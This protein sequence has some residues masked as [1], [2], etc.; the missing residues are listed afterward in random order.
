MSM[1]LATQTPAVLIGDP[2]P[3]RFAFLQRILQED[4]DAR[5]YRVGD[6]NKLLEEASKQNRWRLILIADTLPISPVQRRVILLRYFMELGQGWSNRLG[7][8]VTTDHNPD[9]TGIAN[10]PIYLH[11]N[12]GSTRNTSTAAERGRIVNTL[13]QFGRALTNIH[14]IKWNPSRISS[15]HTV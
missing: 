13:N 11:I 6:F 14:K 10:Q 2:D 1:S 8:I 7:C 5:A 4:F 9:L 15:T 12:P 3:E